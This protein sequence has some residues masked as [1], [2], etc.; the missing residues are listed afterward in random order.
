MAKKARRVKAKFKGNPVSTVSQFDK[1]FDQM[2]HQIFQSNY[3][4]A[5][6][7]GR[8][9]LN[10]LSLRP[11]Q[12]ADVL[13][14]FGIA[15]AMLQEFP[16]SYEAF[17]E[18]LTINSN[19]AELWLNRGMASRYTSRFGRSLR[20]Y[21]RA[22]ELNTIPDLSKRIDSEIKFATKMVK[23]SLKLRGPGFTLDQLIEQEDLFQRGLQTMQAGQ[24]SEAEQAFRA[25]IAMG[26]CLPQPWGN[27]GLCLLMQ[28][29]YD[30]TEEALK[31][32]LVIEPTYAIAKNNL[33]A[34]PEF[35]RNGP[36]NMFGISEP[37]KDAKLKQS[38]TFIA[39]QK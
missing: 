35:R 9:L 32:A 22:K 7:I 8:W 12:R 16:E 14:Q 20:D 28:E 21:E 37:F 17:T 26:D 11:S 31:R 33:R 4:E 15:L 30:E 25:S 18:A 1:K 39:E 36:P 5:V 13:E 38:I 29:R 6:A 2:G 19:S 27:L 10:E 3:E 23:Q 24:W 34:L